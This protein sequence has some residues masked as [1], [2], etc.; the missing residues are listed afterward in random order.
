M[1]VSTPA[2]NSPAP[3]RKLA[4]IMFADIVGYTAMM[5][6]DEV[7]AIRTRERYQRTLDSV[8]GN[9]TGEIVQYYGDGALVLFPNALEAVLAA[10]SIQRE[11]RAQDPVPCRIGIHLGDVIQDGGNVYGDCV[12]VASRVESAAVPGSVMMSAKVQRE[13]VNHPDIETISLGEYNFKNVKQTIGLFALHGE[14]VVVPELSEVNSEKG[15][16]ASCCIAVLP[17]VEQGGGPDDF[18]A[19]GIAEEIVNGLTKIEGLSVM[20]QATVRALIKAG[21][22]ILEQ[23]R[24]TGVPHLLQGKVRRAGPRVR[25]SVSLVNTSDGYQV[26]ADTYDRDIDDIFEVQDDIAARVVN[27]LKGQFQY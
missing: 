2:M 5:Q 7:A 23:A 18:L 10:G 20:S 17:F 11:L 15:Q 19:E 26:W 22:N 14:G 4:A 1:A 27:G 24:T 25:V 16:R 9:G 21:D 8:I 6:R 3:E 13:L 12:N